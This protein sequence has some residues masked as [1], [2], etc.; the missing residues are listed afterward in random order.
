V[1]P[2]AASVS[3]EQTLEGSILP[4]FFPDAEPEAQPTLVLLTGQ[5]GAGASRATGRVLAEYGGGMAAL[6]AADLEAFHSDFR[7][8]TEWVAADRARMTADWLRQCLL[9]A[10]QTH[11]SLLLDGSFTPTAALATADRFAAEGFRT[12]IAVVAARRA[13]SLLA[14]LSTHLS[15]MQAGR[16]SPLVSRDVHDQGFERTRAL[17]AQGE[18]AASVDRLT[19]FGRDGSFAF[20]GERDGSGSLHGAADALAAA[21]AKPLTVTQAIA[22]FGEL[23]RV[24]EYVR[25]TRNPRD[26]VMAQLVEL[27]ELA[28][29]EM[30]PQL[31]LPRASQARDRQ[32]MR[33]AQDLLTLRRMRMP[34]DASAPSVS[35]RG[36]E[37]GGPSL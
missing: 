5:A 19:I 6:T 20:D 24:T 15:A 33:L 10:R 21:Q 8:K 1:N 4:T 31:P 29:Q 37:Q 30:V 36:P 26:D 32:E 18:G 27:H 7:S 22:W 3:L 14:S 23:R 35:V 16:R 17:V 11:R 13:E 12:R 2:A 9:H 34:A 28:L 25:S